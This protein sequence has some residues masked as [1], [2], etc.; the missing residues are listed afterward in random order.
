MPSATWSRASS[1]LAS[2][3]DREAEYYRLLRGVTENAV[4]EPWILY[5]LNAV[6][7]MA[8][9]TRRRILEIRALMDETLSVAKK[10]L[11][12]HVYSKELIELLFH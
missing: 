11:P 1:P 3:D 6:E 7:V 2:A 5:M 12:P 9:L 8:G 10:K 4:W